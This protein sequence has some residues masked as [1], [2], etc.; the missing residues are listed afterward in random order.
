MRIIIN[1][2]LLITVVV[3]LLREHKTNNKSQK[4]LKKNFY[5]VLYIFLLFILLDISANVLIVLTA[6]LCFGTCE[7]INLVVWI[8]NSFFTLFLGLL[9]FLYGLTFKNKKQ[10]NKKSNLF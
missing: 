8:E 7:P 10:D 4:K 9:I 3:Y 2:I 6:I 5:I 1:F